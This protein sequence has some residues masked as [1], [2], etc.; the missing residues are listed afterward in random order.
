MLGALRTIAAGGLHFLLAHEVNLL[1]LGGLLA[2][3]RP[4]DSGELLLLLVV[5]EGVVTYFWQ[6]S[7]AGRLNWVPLFAALLGVVLLVLKFTVLEAFILPTGGMAETLIGSHKTAT[8]PQCGLAFPVNASREAETIP[9]LRPDR[10]TVCECPNCRAEID[11]TRGPRPAVL[12]GGDRFLVTK[13]T[14]NPPFD[15]G[16][17]QVVVFNYPLARKGVPLRFI[18]RL[19]GLPGETIAIRAGKLYVLSPDK[20]PRLSRPPSR[21]EGPGEASTVRAPGA[22]S[23]AHAPRSPRSP[24]EVQKGT[25]PDSEQAGRAESWL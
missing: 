1:L 8:C 23:P 13:G 3:Q 5:L 15:K 10:I 6:R 9:G 4:P 19:I 24:G 7:V 2:T 20:S 22:G 14:L 21:A 17:F 11:L 12:E 25:V 18:Q 16:R